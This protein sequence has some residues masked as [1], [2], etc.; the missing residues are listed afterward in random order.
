MM[1]VGVALE[2]AAQASTGLHDAHEPEI[3]G[4]WMRIVHRDVSPHNIMV[5]LDFGKGHRF[6]SGSGEGA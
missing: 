4:E 2:I 5:G 3:H 1:P 6:W